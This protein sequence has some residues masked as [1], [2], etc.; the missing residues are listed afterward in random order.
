MNTLRPL[1][2]AVFALT[3]AWPA[4]ASDYDGRFL[5]T[6][7]IHLDALIDHG[8]DHYGRHHSPM[9]AADLSL[10]TL[11]LPA[12]RPPTPPGVTDYEFKRYSYGGSNL[13]WDILT[14]RSM[15]LASEITGDDSY[16]QAA[17]DCLHFFTQYAQSPYTN[18]FAWGQ[19]AFW[20]F[21]Q[22]H[23]AI[24]D[25]NER[26]RWFGE[27]RHEFESFTPP[28]DLIWP[29]APQAVLNFAEGIHDWH[30][31][32]YDT[33]VFD[34]HAPMYHP[35]TPGALLTPDMKRP[36]PPPPSW[37]ESAK[38]LVRTPREPRSDHP[39]AW[40]RHSGLYM[41]TFAFAHNKTGAEKY[42]DWILGLS[43]LYWNMRDPETNRV[44]TCLSIDDATGEVI[45]EVRQ[46]E[47]G[48]LDEQ[49]YWKLMASLQMLDHP[50][51]DT[52]RERG[53]A[54][55]HSWREGRGPDSGRWLWTSSSPQGSIQ[56]QAFALA[57]KVSGDEA[58]RDWLIEWAETAMNHR[59]HAQDDGK[60]D[61]FP[62]RYGKMIIALI[63]L[64][65]I[66]GDWAYIEQAAQV[67]D[68]GIAL[69]QHES[70]LF[71][72]VTHVERENGEWTRTEPYPYYNNHTGAQTFLYALMQLHILEAQLPFRIEHNY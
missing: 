43:D 35:I 45:P 42:A 13:Y 48:I 55:M 31:H 44:Y 49:A 51:G 34:R 28:L 32:D 20:D 41:V 30:I 67:A 69:L 23:E 36:G 63:Q 25:P 21:R 52:L 62:E 15:Y 53:L 5:S 33:F 65:E 68:E 6:V 50:V 11:A 1:I 46:T 56:G 47:R 70:G 54:Y 10:D 66:T 39:Q 29:F 60:W 57:Y 64:R 3:L 19:H 17:T 18:L 40:Q 14:L 26:W 22:E 27:I 59:P 2:T 37:W 58:F 72:A 24:D 7:R 71:H 61:L 12:E 16:A 38:A 4:A 8:R 9:F